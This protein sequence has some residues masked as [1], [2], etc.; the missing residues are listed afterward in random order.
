MSNLLFSNGKR[1]I[2]LLGKTQVFRNTCTQ[3]DRSLFCVHF[4]ALYLNALGQSQF[5]Q[6]DRDIKLIIQLCVV[7]LQML[8][9]WLRV[10][11]LFECAR[12]ASVERESDR[13]AG[14]KRQKS[15]YFYLFL[16][17]PPCILSCLYL[18]HQVNILLRLQSLQI[19]LKT[20]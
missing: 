20:K 17:P 1:S 10:I 12:D 2:T 15:P 8:I 6:I 3:M 5:D 11:F 18:T 19:Q 14:A 4:N 9:S 13:E 16:A 7:S